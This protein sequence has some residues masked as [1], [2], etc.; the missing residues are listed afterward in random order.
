MFQGG[1]TIVYETV[2]HLLKHYLCHL[3]SVPLSFFFLLYYFLTFSFLPPPYFLFVACL[4][5][6]MWR[7]SCPPSSLLSYFDSSTLW[8]AHSPS[9][10][11]AMA[12]HHCHI[13]CGRWMLHQP[14][15]ACTVSN[16]MHV[17]SCVYGCWVVLMCVC[18]Q[19]VDPLFIICYLILNCYLL[20]LNETL[21]Y[22]YTKCWLCHTYSD[23]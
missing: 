9:S 5:D 8:W 20:Y 10:S 7:I 15:M 12:G 1:A 17:E 19:E 21:Y 3:L 14:D 2:E 16:Q 23:M 11:S 18:V 4:Q 13:S 22:T 6:S